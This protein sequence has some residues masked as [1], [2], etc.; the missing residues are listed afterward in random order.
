MK[1]IISIVAIM[2]FVFTA[3][4]AQVNYG[5]KGGL[6][7][8]SAEA[9]E[10]GISFDYDAKLGLGLGGFVRLDLSE[11]FQL[12][13]E[14]MY[15]QKNAELEGSM[16]VYSWKSKIKLD[17]LSIPIMA[18][19]YITEGLNIYAG[20]QIEFLLSAKDEWEEN[21][22]GDIS[23]GEDDIKKDLKGMNF[24]LG[25]GAGYE[26]AN[27]L[28]FE[29]RYVIDLTD[30]NDSSD[31]DMKDAEIKTKGFYFGLTYAFGGK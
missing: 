22:D 21:D 28:G 5:V 6:S 23:S 26:L 18:K 7:F 2:A 29:A 14:L 16:S 8:Y 15:L 31:I 9:S 30:Q 25:F 12:Q 24:G 3:S 10:E 27:G 13:P 1:R 11:K 20:P 17:Y 19:Y 4:F